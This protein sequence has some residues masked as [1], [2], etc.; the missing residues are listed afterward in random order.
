MEFDEGDAH[1]TDGHRKEVI[2]TRSEEAERQ[3][4][5]LNPFFCPF[6]CPTKEGFYGFNEAGL[7]DVLHQRTECSDERVSRSF[8]VH[9]ICFAECLLHEV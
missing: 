9:L 1:E 8:R 6:S 5:A 3:G 7:G 4:E 2:A